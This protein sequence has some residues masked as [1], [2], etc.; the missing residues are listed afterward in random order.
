MLCLRAD[1]GNQYEMRFM[2][3]QKRLLFFTRLVSIGSGLVVLGSGWLWPWRAVSASN[4]IA[5]ICPEGGLQERGSQYQAGGIILT[6]F[7]SASMWVYN[8]DSNRRY[9][10]PETRPCGSNCRLSPDA[11]WITYVD[12]TTDSYAKMRLDGTQRTPLVDYAAD[13]EWWS[14]DTLLIWTPT[15]DAYLRVENEREREYLNARGVVNIQPGGRWGVV[16]EQEND[17]FR[18]ALVNLETRSAETS[19]GGRIEMGVHKSYYNAVVWS[20]N[21]QWLAYAAPGAIEGSSA[22]SSEIYGVQPIAGSQPQL[23]TDLTATY[24]AVRINGLTSGDLSWSPDG[25]Y[26]A[27]WVIKLSGANP[28]STAE[29]ATV[30]VLNTSTGE[31]RAYCGFNTTEHTPNPPRLIWS[32]GSTHLALGGNVPGDDKGYLLLALDIQSGIFTV[33]SEGIYPTLGGANPVAWGYAP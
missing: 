11:R 33:L 13:V 26:L 28:E 18:R 32:P 7:D 20:P 1:L 29:S 9:P 3:S 12:S 15:K 14:A 19:V 6:A 22:E 17:I 24:G 10:L 30:H 23:W 8:I 2:H 27:F 5:Y 25:I 4:S 31:L 16:V 21:G